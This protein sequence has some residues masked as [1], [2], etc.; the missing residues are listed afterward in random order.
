M[1][2]KNAFNSPIHKRWDLV[3]PDFKWHLDEHCFIS[4]CKWSRGCYNTVN[5][6]RSVTTQEITLKRR[7]ALGPQAGLLGLL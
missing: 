7:N 4:M 2:Q 3:V 5:T 1:N 6:S